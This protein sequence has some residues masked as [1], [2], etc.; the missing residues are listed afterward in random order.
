MSDRLDELASEVEKASGFNLSDETL[1]KRF[2]LAAEAFFK[3]LRDDLETRSKFSM[4]VT[5]GGLGMTESQAEASMGLLADRRE[6][7]MI[8][9]RSRTEQEKRRFVSERADR[10]LKEEERRSSAERSELDRRFTLLTGSDSSPRTGSVPTEPPPLASPAKP[11]PQVGPKVVPVVSGSRQGSGSVQGDA[12]RHDDAAVAET[13]RDLFGDAP[14]AP[15][16]TTTPPP[17]N[18]PLAN[19]ESPISDVRP[20]GAVGEEVSRPVLPAGGSGVRPVEVGSI[21][22]SVVVARESKPMFSSPAVKVQSVRP[23]GIRPS[24]AVVSRPVV[25]DVARAPRRLTGPVEELAS[26][27]LQDFRRLSRDPSEAALKIRDKVDLLKDESFADKTAGVRA[28]RDSAV[29]RLYL[30]TLR[31]SLE[32]TPVEE[33]LTAMAKDGEALTKPEFDALMKLNRGLRF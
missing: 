32:G 23:A 16:A 7:F 31:R 29:N 25:S 9:L 2:F 1:R 21:R 5:S 20:S 22:Q 27:T 17:P 6:E 18:L 4:S 11:R 10:Q 3:D 12:S 28:W 8:G 30:E 19:G 14:E 13:F 24:S 26:L 15:S 33:V